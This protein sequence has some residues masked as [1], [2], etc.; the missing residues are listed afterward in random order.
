MR[1]MWKGM[2]SF[3]LV[4]IP[5]EMYVAAREREFK[6]VLLHD[7][8]HSPIRYARM[9]KE[10]NKEVPWS[11][12][13][14]GYESEKGKFVIMSEEDFKQASRERTDSIDIKQF[15]FEEE[16]D[17]IYFEKPYYLEPQKGAAKA[18]ALLVSA[19][20]KSKKAGIATYVIH[21][22]EH[23]GLIKAHGDMLVLNQLR[24]KS[25]IVATND[26]NIPKSSRQS[27]EEMAMALKL[28]EHMTSAFKPERY[29]D[30]YSDELRKIIAKKAKGQK[31]T[32]T[33]KREQKAKVID[34][35]SALKASLDEKK[36]KKRA[37]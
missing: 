13:V 37:S 28:V 15:V 33:K 9:C 27:A 5:A 11:H 18:Y 7:D 21:N 29:K 10:E 12:V 22:R 6:F 16:V 20:K 17:S 3:G 31:I 36:T 24:Y 19:L 1:S 4:N 30:A 34:L 25:E 23:L 32:V 2:I 14:R 35:M 26:L 8:D